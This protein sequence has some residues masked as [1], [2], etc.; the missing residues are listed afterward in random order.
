MPCMHRLTVQEG[1]KGE[2]W[3]HAEEGGRVM[4]QPLFADKRGRYGDKQKRFYKMTVI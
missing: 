1:S 3:I 2:S 4:F